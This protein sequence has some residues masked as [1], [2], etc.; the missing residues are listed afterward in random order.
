MNIQSIIRFIKDTFFSHEVY[1]TIIKKCNQDNIWIK[2]IVGI[3]AF[4]LPTLHITMPIVQSLL[5]DYFESQIYYNDDTNAIHTNEIW[6]KY[7]YFLIAGIMCLTRFIKWLE[8]NELREKLEYLQSIIVEQ[9][10]KLAD[11]DTKFADHD[12][13]LSNIKSTL[14]DTTFIVEDHDTRLSNIKST[15]DDTTLIVEDH[16]TKLSELHENYIF[17]NAFNINLQHLVRSYK[18]SRDTKVPQ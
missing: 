12:T 9:K 15:L 5:E 3:I 11:H 2:V 8:R 14:D 7:K 17:T 13:R 4:L 18:L 6:S 16:D 10:M 1:D